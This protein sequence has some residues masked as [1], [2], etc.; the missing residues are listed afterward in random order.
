MGDDLFCLFIKDMVHEIADGG[1][2][3]CLLEPELVF[4]FGMSSEIFGEF[5]M[6]LDSFKLLKD[7]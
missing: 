4:F 6:K 3:W 7:E 5:G 2:V 1:S